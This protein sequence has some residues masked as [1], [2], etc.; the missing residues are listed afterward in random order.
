MQQTDGLA[1]G[2]EHRLELARQPAGDRRE[3]GEV[4]ETDT[5]G[6]D[7]EDAAGWRR[8]DCAATD[9]RRAQRPRRPCSEP[10]RWP[11]PGQVRPRQTPGNVQRDPRAAR[12]GQKCRRDV[13]L[14]GILRPKRSVEPGKE[15]AELGARNVQ[16]LHTPGIDR[17]YVL[18]LRHEQTQPPPVQ[19]ALGR[20]PGNGAPCGLGVEENRTQ[21]RA[22]GRVP[23]AS[24]RHGRRVDRSLGH[25]HPFRKG[26]PGGRAAARPARFAA[27]EAPQQ[28]VQCRRLPGDRRIATVVHDPPAS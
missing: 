15:T 3:P 19:H 7:E 9:R 1:H 13:P 6:S 8:L 22:S 11:R 2:D 26:L 20:E 21:N 18:R 28:E 24:D 27:V 23:A 5:V 17:T 12:T 10:P 25:R 16:H 14:R 4:P